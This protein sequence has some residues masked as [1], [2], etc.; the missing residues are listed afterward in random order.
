MNPEPALVVRDE[1]NGREPRH[2]DPMRPAKGGTVARTWDSRAAVREALLRLPTM[3]ED[4]RALVG[5][6]SPSADLAAV[7]RSAEAVRMLLDRRL[8]VAAEVLV[9]EGVAHVRYRS[10]SPRV[11]LLAHH[12][13]V[14]PVGTLHAIPFSVR[15]GIMRG[16]GCLD[17]KVGLVQA[18][19]ALAILRNQLGDDGLRAVEL[20]VTGDEECGSTTSRILIEADARGMLAALVLEAAADGGALKVARK[21]AA[22]YRLNVV[23][24]AAHAGLEPEA[25]VNAGI[26]LAHQALAVERLGDPALQ[27]TV[28]PTT[29]AVGTTANTVPAHASLDIDVR[30]WTTGERERVDRDL[31]RLE[32]VLPGAELLI[33]GGPGRPPFESAASEELFRRWG[34]AAGR[35]GYGDVAGVAVGGASDG[36]FTAGVGVPTLDGLGAVGGGAH[37]A[38]E[39][40][41]ISQI[42]VQT[43]VLATLLADLLGAESGAWR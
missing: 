39:H 9:R 31:R 40:V 8:D 22:V 36:N 12:D 27:T 10:T 43:A 38:D 11:V 17:M 35:C 20:L 25:G 23:G 29:M 14:W 26:E 4:A 2:A 21:G 28:T 34:L 42:P 6:E 16:P 24:R 7:G 30:T 15:D 13:T 3:L 18:V 32:P 1:P 41:E 19:H 33:D 37:A 5:T